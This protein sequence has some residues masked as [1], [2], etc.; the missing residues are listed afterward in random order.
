MKKSERIAVALVLMAVGALFVILR[1][2]FI[3]ILMTVAGG[4]IIVIGV[5][6]IF[7][8]RI[9]QAV[10]KI[11]AGILLIIAGW[12]LVRAVLY[13]L[14]AILLIVG[15]LL[16]YDKIKNGDCDGSFFQKLIRYIPSIGCVLIGVLL[17]FHGGEG[18]SVI[19]VLGGI[20]TVLVG[21]ALLLIALF[22]EE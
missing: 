2:N 1:A 22:E 20:L 21:G 4:G 17:L 16:L 7:G 13:V 12:A 9:P 11:V 18:I 14:S 8:Q 10:V 15:I 19:L 6:D 5:V 3:G